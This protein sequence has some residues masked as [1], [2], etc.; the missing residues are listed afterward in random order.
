VRLFFTHE[1]YNSRD[2]ALDGV[3]PATIP[4]LVAFGIQPYMDKVNV[5]GLSLRYQFGAGKP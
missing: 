1:S 4:G 3:G 2:W 5:V